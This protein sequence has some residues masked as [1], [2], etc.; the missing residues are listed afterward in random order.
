MRKFICVCFLAVWLSACHSV[1]TPLPSLSPSLPGELTPYRSPTPSRTSTPLPPAATLALTP[2]PTATPFTHII[3]KNDTLL[4]IAFRYGVSLEELQAANPG[5][6]PGFLVIGQTLI[7]PLEGLSSSDV[8]LSTPIP[9]AW[10]GPYCYP[11]A[12]NGLW[13]LLQVNNDQSTALENLSGWVSLYNAQGNQVGG[14]AAASPLNILPAGASIPLVAFFPSPLPEF[15]LVQGQ[16]LTALPVEPGD[17]RYLNAALQVESTETSAN[18]LESSVR[19]QVLLLEGQIPS[20]IWVLAVAY[21]ETGQVVG[22][23]KIEFLA[24]CGMP[25][26]PTPA[27]TAQATPSIGTPAATLTPDATLPP[28]L[29]CT[30][31][32]ISVYSLAPAI[33]RVELLLEA[34]P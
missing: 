23:R 10:T 15:S 3:A 16:L 19:G 29:P 20:Q 6:D 33:R 25:S 32:E 34:R 11:S 18:G 30:S 14:Q 9:V 8:L 22:Q 5:V 12:D 17:S 13:C 28:L 7:I 21:D 24:P 27:N 2:L 31:F 1:A 4:A 26:S